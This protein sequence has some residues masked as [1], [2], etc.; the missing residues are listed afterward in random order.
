M[1]ITT[2]SE[3]LMLDLGIIF[4]M[5]KY[6]VNIYI[7]IYIIFRP[8]MF[9]HLQTLQLAKIACSNQLVTWL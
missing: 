9:V 7:F 8:F 1:K 4:A 2:Y 3:H 5:H 6:V